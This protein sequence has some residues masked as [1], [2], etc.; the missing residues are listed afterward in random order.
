MFL[1]LPPLSVSDRASDV[2]RPSPLEIERLGD[3][4]GRVLLPHPKEFVLQWTNSTTN[5]EKIWV[6]QN[7]QGKFKRR[8]LQWVVVKPGDALFIPCNWWHATLNIGE[9]V[10][11]GGQ[12][13]QG[14]VDGG[15]CPR[16]LYAE[17]AGA[18]AGVSQK[19]KQRKA[20]S[21]G[22]AG[23]L[24][25][26]EASE[27]FEALAV[28]CAALRWNVHCDSLRSELLALAK[29]GDEAVTLLL[30]VA[31]RMRR[32]HAEGVLNSVQ[33]SAVL[34]TS[35]ASVSPRASHFP[36]NSKM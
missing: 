34:G 3:A 5:A 18:M 24:S 22:T 11:V 26:S 14:K 23:V 13:L 28:A 30:G 6:E 1:L 7:A 32:A 2:Q 9:T 15:S 20:A 21:A 31:E 35:L 12:L 4:L 19:L 27:G 16:D 8:L 25:P 10:A 33:F 36:H 29:R 17:A